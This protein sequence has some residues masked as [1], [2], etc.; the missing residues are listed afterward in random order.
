VQRIILLMLFV[1]LSL[2]FVPDLYAPETTAHD[3]LGFDP[4]RITEDGAIRDRDSAIRAWILGD[5]VYD[6]R[7]NTKYYIQGNRVY[8]VEFG[9]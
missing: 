7:W 2:L 4:F 8:R 9:G 3:L 5:T 6:A 1:V